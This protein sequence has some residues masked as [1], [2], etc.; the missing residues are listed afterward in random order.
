MAHP[1]L[2]AVPVRTR[3]PLHAPS[4]S[5]LANRQA[6]RAKLRAKRAGEAGFTLVELGAVVTIVGI[7]AVLAVVGYRKLI[8]QAHNAEATQMV[9]SIR[10]AQEAYKAETGTYAD[11]SPS[12]SV[13]AGGGTACT[14][15]GAQ[16]PN[17]NTPTIGTV[18]KTAWGAACTAA[19]CGGVTWNSI[20]VHVD[21]PVIYGYT[22]IAGLSGVTPTAI[23]TM[24]NN[25]AAYTLNF[26]SPTSDWFLVA[27]CGDTDGDGIFSAYVSGSFSNEIFSSNDGE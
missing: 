4:P 10:T 27:A 7:L 2:S 19:Q 25:G 14:A 3:L 23:A 15:F 9:N 18:T 1:V 20:P 16:Y 11:I 13:T 24:Y 12:L 26:P 22:T 6:R 8:S 21:G 5:P 17:G